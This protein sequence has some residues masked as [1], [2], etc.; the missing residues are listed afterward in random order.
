MGS[1]AR[2]NQL[3]N[4]ELPES[5]EFG[6]GR[7]RCMLLDAVSFAEHFRIRRG[8][9]QYSIMV[10]RHAQPPNSSEVISSWPSCASGRVALHTIFFFSL[11]EAPRAGIASIARGALFGGTL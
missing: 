8:L 1:L 7:Y 9:W 3:I 10:L 6:A 11:Q 5:A 2:I 4:I